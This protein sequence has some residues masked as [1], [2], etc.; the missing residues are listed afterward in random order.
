MSAAD[1]VLLPVSDDRAARPAPPVFGLEIV[2]F[3]SEDAPGDPATIGEFWLENDGNADA[4]PMGAEFYAALAA[5]PVGQRGVA[6]LGCGGGFF[7]ER[8]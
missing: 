4:M 5:L 6:D 7:F 1:L 8:R 3:E 2:V